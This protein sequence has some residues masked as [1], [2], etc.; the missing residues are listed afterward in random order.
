MPKL[1]RTGN[2][3]ASASLSFSIVF[4]KKCLLLAVYLITPKSRDGWLY[5]QSVRNFFC[6]YGEVSFQT[7]SI[8]GYGS[9][10]FVFCRATRL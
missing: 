7:L 5:N 4:I 3:Y 6:T 10:A 9:I 1:L 2:T 8:A